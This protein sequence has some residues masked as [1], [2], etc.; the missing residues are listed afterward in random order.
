M[1]VSEESIASGVVRGQQGEFS[2]KAE[3]EKQ[4]EGHFGGE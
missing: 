4:E 3:A 1:C 2:S